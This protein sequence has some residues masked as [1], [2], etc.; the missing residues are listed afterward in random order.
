MRSREAMM[1]L[2]SLA[3]VFTDVIVVMQ[4]CLV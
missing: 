2:H 4:Y 3:N 1:E